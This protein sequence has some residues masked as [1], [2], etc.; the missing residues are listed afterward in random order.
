MSLSQLEFTDIYPDRGS[1]PSFRDPNTDR[2]I[3]EVILRSGLK[4]P[5]PWE[6]FKLKVKLGSLIEERVDPL[7]VWSSI[8]AD[9]STII[10]QRLGD[11]DEEKEI[12][13][14]PPTPQRSPRTQTPKRQPPQAVIKLPLPVASAIQEGSKP[15]YVGSGAYGQVHTAGYGQVAKRIENDANGINPSALR[16]ISALKALKSDYVITLIAFDITPERTK[17]TLPRYDSDLTQ[18]IRKFT[19]LSGFMIKTIMFKLLH[20]LYDAHRVSIAHRD[21]KP[22]NIVINQDNIDVRIIDWGLSRFLQTQD[23]KLFTGEVQTLWYRSIELLLGPDRY[24]SKID[25]WSLGCIMYELAAGTPLFQGG[26]KQEQTTLIFEELGT[27]TEQTW[28]GV[29]LLPRMQNPFPHYPGNRLKLKKVE[30]SPDG[31]DVLMK[32]LILNPDQRIG[33]V[34]ALNHDYFKE[35]LIAPVTEIKLVDALIDFNKIA[36][37]PASISKQ[38]DVTASMRVTVID[39]LFEVCKK[40]KVSDETAFLMVFF[41][42]YF[43]SL[44]IVSRKHLQLLGCGCLLV[45]GKINELLP[46]RGQDLVYMA[47]NSFYLSQLLGMEEIIVNT[48][49]GHLYIATEYTFMNLYAAG[50]IDENMVRLLWFV[51]L[52]VEFRKYTPKVIGAGI[53][54]YFRPGNPD[55]AVTEFVEQLKDLVNTY[56]SRVPASKLDTYFQKHLL[57][58]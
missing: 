5:V 49:G 7:V 44:R 58:L 55:P 45:A 30:V 54:E 36:I 39:W 3:Y 13:I 51:V 22:A 46:F 40:F 21:I 14:S 16:E 17:L 50:L 34:D 52:Q 57:K 32:M 29:T 9:A 11:G 12:I 4:F 15:Q 6:Q 20:G 37:N 23:P 8:N 47:A 48:L 27:P 42:N 56:K 41:L 10:N 43:L 35:L 31:L 1:F 19:P 38:P 53:V 24:T 28:P 33:Y 25:I 18:F 26:S 2:F